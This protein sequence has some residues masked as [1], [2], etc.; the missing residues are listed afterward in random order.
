MNLSEG[1]ALQPSA[2]QQLLENPMT[3]RILVAAALVVGALQGVAQADEKFERVKV[4]LERN[5]MDQDAEVKF[6]AIG[7]KGGLTSLKVVA[8]DGRTVVDLKSPDSKL[9]IRG[10]S[11]ES[12]E[13]KNDGRVQADFPAGAYTF[14]GTGAGGERLEGKAMLSHTFPEP[15]TLVRPKPEAKNVPTKGLQIGWKSV[16]GLGSCVVVIEQEASG[17]TIK[18]NLAAD[19]SSFPVPD[20]F[21]LPDT[22][23][24]V[25]VGTVAKDGNSSFIEA[26]FTTAKKQ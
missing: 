23:Y 2:S 16:K 14:S 26:T 4:F 18:A 25:A 20:G 15:A 17:R 21:L 6:E 7:G 10:M 3:R 8:P 13:P 11:L 1:K 19:A 9:G 12:P 24:K 22:E 5:V